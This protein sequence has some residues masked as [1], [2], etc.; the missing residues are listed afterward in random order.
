[1]RRRWSLFGN[2]R[3]S[4]PHLEETTNVPEREAPL[5]FRTVNVSLQ[6][7][8]TIS[9]RLKNGYCNSYYCGCGF[10]W[11]ESHCHTESVT[12]SFM[13]WSI[14]EDKPK[15]NAVEEARPAIQFVTS[16][17]FDLVVAEQLVERGF[18]CLHFA[19]D[20]CKFCSFW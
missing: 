16:L 15:T 13:P 6:I 5:R 2:G 12:D 8:L 19:R 7:W 17:K 4:S 14:I 10:I 1:M 9:Q 11:R 20:F 18:I 3:T